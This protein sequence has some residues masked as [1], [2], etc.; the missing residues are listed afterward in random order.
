M[1]KLDRDYAMSYVLSV[2]KLLFNYFSKSKK[3]RIQISELNEYSSRIV[4]GCKNGII[5]D[6][7]RET[8]DDVINQ[9][10]DVFETD[11]ED[12]VLIDRENII[13]NNI[14]LIN[15]AIPSYIRNI[16]E[17]TNA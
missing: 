13:I 5:I 10:S 6:L 7:N 15:R 12:I 9:R 14:G 17:T 2:E 3:E 8:I 1:S 4:R 16:I 11:N